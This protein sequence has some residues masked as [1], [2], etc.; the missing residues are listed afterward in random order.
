[1]ADRRPLLVAFVVFVR[2]VAIV[3]L[4]FIGSIVSAPARRGA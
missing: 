2:F 1:M 3:F 4:L